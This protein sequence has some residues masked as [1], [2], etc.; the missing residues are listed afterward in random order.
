NFGQS[1]IISVAGS[2][3]AGHHPFAPTQTTEPEKASPQASLV[4]SYGQP[5]FDLSMGASRTVTPRGG[6]NPG[7]YKPT[8]LQRTN[9]LDSTIGYGLPRPFDGQTFS[10]GYSFARIGRQLDFPVEKLDPYETPAIP[11]GGLVG[12]LRLGWSYNN[13]QRYLWSVG[14]ENGLAASLAF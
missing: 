8:V 2:D 11:Q 13:T 7:P 14:P 5:P 1:V 6:F 3:V 12:V 10:A 9:D 4:Y